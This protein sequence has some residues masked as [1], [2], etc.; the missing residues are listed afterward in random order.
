MDRVLF[1]VRGLPNS[2]KTTLGSLIADECYQKDDAYERWAA[3]NGK[4]YSEAFETLDRGDV[5]RCHLADIVS[6]MK[7]EVPRIAVCNTSITR[8]MVRELT[9]MANAH[10]YKAFCLISERLPS[11]ADNGHNVPD[12]VVRGMAAGFQMVDPRF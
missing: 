10:G 11:F 9:M 3:E 8:A 4:T 12:L 6:A 5:I 1:I 7:R 2:G